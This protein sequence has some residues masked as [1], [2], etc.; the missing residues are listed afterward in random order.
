MC[1]MPPPSEIKG[2]LKSFFDATLD[3]KILKIADF[4]YVWLDKY[5]K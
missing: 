5:R 2:T 4:K 3:S 1:G